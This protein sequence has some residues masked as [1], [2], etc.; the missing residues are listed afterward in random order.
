MNARIQSVAFDRSERPATA[1]IM[2]DKGLVEVEWRDVGGNW[3]WFTAGT[4]DAKKAA[5]PAIERLERMLQCAT[6]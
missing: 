1:I 3:C 6:S 2:T 4:M 5:V